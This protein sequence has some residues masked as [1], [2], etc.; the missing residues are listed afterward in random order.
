MKI[1]LL[2]WAVI[3]MPV[4]AQNQGGGITQPSPGGL[5]VYPGSG[6]PAGVACTAGQAFQYQGATYL[7]N[8]GVL[9]AST[10][11]PPTQPASTIT[12]NNT[13]GT[14]AP[15]G[16]TPAQTAA[17]LGNAVTYSQ[18]G[19]TNPNVLQSA[20]PIN[21][22]CAG[23]D[24]SGNFIGG[25]CGAAGG[26]NGVTYVGLT[27]T[28]D[29]TNKTFTLA[30]SQAAVQLFKNGQLLQ[31][32]VDY[33]LSGTGITTTAAPISSDVFQVVVANTGSTVSSTLAVPNPTT[34][35]FAVVWNSNTGAALGAGLP[36]SQSNLA[37]ALLETNTAGEVP[38]DMTGCPTTTITVNYTALNTDCTITATTASV[39]ITM[40][41]SP[42]VGK[43]YKIDNKTASGTITA[44]AGGTIV[45]QGC[46]TTQT[47]TL[48]LPA[49]YWADLTWDGTEWRIGVG[50][51][52]CL[53]TG[54]LQVNGTGQAVN[55]IGGNVLG[56]GT[57]TIAPN[58][59]GAGT[60]GTAACETSL[61]YLCNGVSG[62][63]KIVTAGVPT[64]GTV[65]VV[66]F[67]NVSL[68]SKVRTCNVFAAGGSTFFS[69]LAAGTLTYVES[70]SAL[71]IST[72]T[73]ALTTGLTGDIK[74][75]CF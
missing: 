8:G 48:S 46:A 44:T 26:A 52:G 37:S 41:T 34:A 45:F 42:I 6:S 50:P 73:T 14:S 19:G 72:Q 69:V 60:G 75:Q 24:G 65:A 63:V 28:Q 55:S 29:G 22:P 17:V 68:S 12:C 57:A 62:V 5:P 3:A 54:A 64:V 58:T 38:G 31:P 1:L 13:G 27:G 66:T 36:I 70:N 47:V 4:F 2:L 61:A 16:C 20:I 67:P 59:T 32:N 25:T 49:T 30:S 53:Y 71:T 40:P 9:A 21:Q 10:A 18:L 51:Q 11:T 74:Y 15:T 35:G 33:V 39:V 7:C 23:T 43:R 56:F